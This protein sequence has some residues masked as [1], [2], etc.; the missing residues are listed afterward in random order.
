[1]RRTP[2]PYTTLFRSGSMSTTT[3]PAPAFAALPARD[4]FVD[5][6]RLVAVALVVLQ[7]WLMPVLR[8]DGD[9]LH[10][11]NAF[12][13][14]WVWPV[15]WVGQVVPLLFFAGGAAAAMS[16]R[17]TDVAAWVSPPAHRPGARARRRLAPAAPR[18]HRV[19]PARAAG[20]H[21]RALRRGAA[22]VPRLVRRRHRER[23]GPRAA[24]GAGP[25]RRGRRGGGR[26]RPRRRR[27]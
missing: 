11:G 7:H 10:T 14:A 21:R 13:A 5:L 20:A 4:R 18:A 19:R 2:S 1:P 25:R 12:A 17:A 27:P 15:T 8:L 6:V 24:G 9:V 22:V 26:G 3:L 23:P 16:L